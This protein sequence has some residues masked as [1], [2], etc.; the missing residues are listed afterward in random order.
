[1]PR[2]IV[3]HTVCYY[4]LSISYIRKM[5]SIK[6]HVYRVN[7]NVINNCNITFKKVKYQS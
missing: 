6:F 4:A 2:V 7:D 5:M 3:G 1:M